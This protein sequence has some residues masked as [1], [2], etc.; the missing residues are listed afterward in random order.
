MKFNTNHSPPYDK[1]EQVSPLVRRITAKNPGKFT[2][3]GT[4][5]YIVGDES[6]AV[7]DPGPD[8]IQHISNLAAELKGK[9]LT[10]IL[11]T[12]THRDH[13]PA[14]AA[15][16]A[17]AGGIICGFGPHPKETELLD[18]SGAGDIKKTNS[19]DSASSD[20]LEESGDLNFM[21]E[22]FLGHQEILVGKGWTF[23]CLY[24]PGHISNHLCFVLYEEKT[25]FTGDHIM[26]W[27]T[28]IIPPPAGNLEDYLES[29]KLLINR[30]EDTYLPTHGPAIKNGRAYAKS[31]LEHRENRNTQIL[32]CVK[33]GAATIPEVVKIIY[34]DYPEE[35]HK[36]AER[37]V[38]A[39]L[40]Y[41]HKNREVGCDGE[42]G[43]SASFFLN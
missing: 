24:T 37:S 10:H 21:P 35:L 31:L 18:T 23:E 22:K 26:G 1:A 38:W 36:P 14:A 27:S 29:L 3:K 41:L 2:F 19:P 4:G 5:T 6:V 39:H 7:I 25:I 34:K 43:F 17:E 13:S 15:L 32:D 11:V 30:T 40:I 33:K 42:P 9:R 16:Q 20:T 28:S 8:D 12:H